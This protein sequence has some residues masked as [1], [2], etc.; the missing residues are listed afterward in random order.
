MHKTLQM[1]LTSVTVGTGTAIYIAPEVLKQKY[2]LPSDLWSAGIIAYQL[3]TGR[4]PFSGE[5]G[6]E[7][8]TRFME[9][10]QFDHKVR[11]CT[12]SACT[13]ECHSVLGIVT[14]IGNKEKRSA[15]S[16]WRSSSLT[17][18]Y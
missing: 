15:R 4:L 13:D 18:W 14:C 10:Q 2:G 7:V 16:S 1:V 3:V 12:I 6:E 11:I 5:E 8:S 17:T 9:K